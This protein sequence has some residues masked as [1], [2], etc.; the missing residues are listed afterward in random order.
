MNT[1]TS[2][3]YVARYIAPHMYAVK[4]RDGRRPIV[5]LHETMDEAVKHA[6]ALN[7]GVAA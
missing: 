2:P 5:S 6:A 4:S 7:K 1:P 3:A